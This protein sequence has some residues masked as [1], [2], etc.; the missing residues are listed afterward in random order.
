MSEFNLSKKDSNN[1]KKNIIL[2]DVDG[3]I[4]HS[5][6]IINETIANLLNLL[7]NKKKFDIG[8]VGGGKYDKILYQ[9]NNKIIPEHIFSECGSIYHKLN[10]DDNTYDLIYKNN[11]RNFKFYK[12]INLLIK[13]FLNYL[14][15]VDYL[16]TGNF[17]D[18]RDGLIYLSLIGMVANEE[19]RNTFIK[20][21]MEKNY[22]SKVLKILQNKAIELGIEK[23]IDIL[24][25]GSVGIAIYPTKWNKVQII[26]NKIINKNDY[27][28][29]FYFGDKYKKD[30]NDYKILNHSSVIGV[31]IDFLE[32]TI[33][34][35]TNIIYLEF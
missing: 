24:I 13:V 8:I 26:E 14:S 31:R 22:R 20:L 21:D 15:T 32:D 29:I 19:E 35:L 12:E 11:I 30:G 17:V 18:L 3:T 23:E 27:K 1:L 33:E 7:K 5:G 16:L 28:R 2:L 6:N 9:L 34:E 25:G 10:K 4:A